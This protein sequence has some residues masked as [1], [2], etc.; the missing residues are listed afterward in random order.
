MDKKAKIGLVVSLALVLFLAITLVIAVPGGKGKPGGKAKKECNDQIDNDGDGDIDLADAG[1]NNKRDN[2]ETNCGDGVCEGG[3]T[4]DSCAADCV[5]QCNDG[6]DN[7]GDTHI[8]TAIVGDSECV[9]ASDNDESPRDFCNDS[10]G[11]TFEGIKG[12]VSGEDDGVSFSYTDYCLNSTFVMEYY[13][14]G[15]YQDYDPLSSPMVCPSGNET[16]GNETQ[17][18]CIDGACV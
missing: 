1:C 16:Q 15:K 2:D 4:P 12:T 7:D 13:C 3:E 6:I 17:T 8:D 10:D 18:E 9:D 14:G 5:T 11:G